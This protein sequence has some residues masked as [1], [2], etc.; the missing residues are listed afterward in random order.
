MA[1]K[2]PLG[3]TASIAIKSIRHPVSTTG[4][5][6]EQAKGTVALAKLVTEHVGKAAASLAAETASSVIEKAGGRKS[7]DRRAATP[8]HPP[9]AESPTTLRAVPDVN[10]PAHV[11]AENHPVAK[12][13]T[14]KSTAKKATARK[15]PAKKT[16]ATAKKS[17]AKKS[18]AK[19]TAAKKSPAKKTAAKKAP[20]K[21]TAAK[22]AP[23]KKTAERN[24]G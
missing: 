10:E 15:S 11:P 23:A 7:V 14:A 21:K 17:T 22:K 3:K 2:S 1:A 18:P 24:S 8:T 12:K 4:K 16:T 13:A 9:R 20:A 5:I 6:V 19:K